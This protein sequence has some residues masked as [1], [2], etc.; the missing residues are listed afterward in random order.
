M[1][2]AAVTTKDE[3]SA[4]ALS[5]AS[6]GRGQSTY[7]MDTVF[8]KAIFK[9]MTYCSQSGQAYEGIWFASITPCF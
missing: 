3:N 1:T 2:V 4:G 7:P 6:A 8:C 5:P 9:A